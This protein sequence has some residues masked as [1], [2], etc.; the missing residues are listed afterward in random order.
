MQELQRV[1]A[2]SVAEIRQL[3]AD[4]GAMRQELETKQMQVQN[5]TLAEV[6]ESASRFMFDPAAQRSL[7]NPAMNG[8]GMQ[9]TNVNLLMPAGLPHT[10]T[11]HAPLLIRRGG[12]PAPS[13]PCRSAHHSAARCRRARPSRATSRF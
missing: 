10:A 1:Q 2:E 8:G 11:P 5:V 9:N 6:G 4:R 13:S 3:Q 7:A 12:A